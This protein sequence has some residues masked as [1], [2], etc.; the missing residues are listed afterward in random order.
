MYELFILAFLMRGPMH[1][2]KMASIINDM[3][4][5]LAKVSNGRLY[6]LLSKLE[7]DGLIAPADDAPAGKPSDRRQRP[8]TLTSA[9]RKRFHQVMMDTTSN[10]GDYPKL[11]WLKVQFLEFLQPSE[12]LYLLDHYLNYCQTHIFHVQSEMADLAE[13]ARAKQFMTAEQ[14]QTTL[15]TMEHLL[16][17]WRLEFEHARDWREREVARLEGLPASEYQEGTRGNTP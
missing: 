10:P 7:H 1:G 16:S 4:G 15:Y 17:Q 12:R 11:F 14:L 5:P 13:E 8:F 2:Y 3:I 6:P 9:G